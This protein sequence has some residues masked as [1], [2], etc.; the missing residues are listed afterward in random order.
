M[1]RNK[2]V[3][4]GASGFIG[5]NLVRRLISDNNEVYIL[6]RK[7]SYIWRLTELNPQLKEFQVDFHDK[8]LLKE[9]I[10][11]IKPDIIYHLAAYGGYPFQ[12]DLTKML[13]GNIVSTVNILEA[14]KDIG[15]KIFINFGSSS[16][17][18]FKKKPM[19]ETDVLEPGSFYAATKASGTYLCRVFG[20]IYQKPIVTVRPFSVYGPYEE[21]TRLI[22]SSIVACLKGKDLKLT[23]GDQ[24]RDFIY[25]GDFLDGL[26]AITHNPEKVA[27]K[28]INLGTARQYSVNEVVTLIKKITNSK[29]K[30]IWDAYQPRSWD[31]NYWV[32]D[33]KLAKKLLNWEPE[34]SLEEGL[35]KTIAWFKKHIHLYI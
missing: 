10:S 22:P 11:H 35:Q 33:I 34:T 17:Y 31:T 3:V 6:K 1:V 12:E 9:V 5:A 14:S 23:K 21:P 7:D 15:Y 19:K 27:G 24:K 16:E 30:L 32:A 8:A 28:V 2:I 20:N 25:I 29:S 13:N 4:T 18:G 26:F